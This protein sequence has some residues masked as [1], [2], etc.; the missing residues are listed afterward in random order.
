MPSLVCTNPT[1]LLNAARP[2]RPAFWCSATV[3]RAV[4]DGHTLCA[5][6][7]FQF[8]LK[9]SRPEHFVMVGSQP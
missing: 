9:N 4:V 7:E 8:A 5:I 2:A 3:Y 1:T 6:K